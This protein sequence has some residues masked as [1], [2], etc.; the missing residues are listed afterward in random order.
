MT[1]APIGHGTHPMPP[2]P[3]DMRYM[4][5]MTEA[6]ACYPLM[7]QLRPHLASETEFI[8]RWRRQVTAGYR[9]LAIWNEVEPLSLAGFRIQDNLMHGRH[10]YLDDLVT[11]EKERSHGHGQRLLARLV[12]E[13]RALRCSKLVLDTPLANV[14]GHRFY[15]RNGMLATAM[16]FAIPL[17]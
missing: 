4:D 2:L 14:L 13:G 10:L 3:P 11:S 16:R 15:Y 17:G 5:G 7:H 1:E 8:E 6:A 9:M 12:T